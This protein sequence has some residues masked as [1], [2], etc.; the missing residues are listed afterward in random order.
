M[1]DLESL[2]AQHAY[3]KL[4]KVRFASQQTYD[5]RITLFATGTWDEKENN[6][7]TLWKSEETPIGL[8]N[9]V[10]SYEN[11]I[12]AKTAHKGDVRDMQFIGD[13]L[14]LTSSSK[15]CIHVFNCIKSERD[16]AERETDFDIEM[17][18]EDAYKIEDPIITHNLHSF[19]ENK[20]AAATGMAIKP[21]ST[22]DLEIASVGEDGKLVLFK[23]TD[24]NHRQIIDDA[25]ASGLRAV[26]W[27]LSDQIITAGSSGQL[28]LFDCRNS[29]KPCAKFYDPAHPRDSL[30]CLKVNSSQAHQIVSGSS[31]GFVT[32]WDTRNLSK[33]EKQ[34]HPHKNNV[35]EL[36]FHPYRAGILLSCSEDGTIGI[37]DFNP[38]AENLRHHGTLR[39]SI[40]IRKLGSGFNNLAINSIDYNPVARLLIGGNDNQNLLSKELE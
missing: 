12:I 10:P 40:L 17:H 28:R 21:F 18:V 31:Q 14:L 35:Y 19:S 30:N 39:D 9:L 27:P 22:Q 16:E 6:D 15:G 20:S 11:K 24:Q 36:I 1:P 25:D 29:N 2:Y 4:S 37:M 7:L 23:V 26:S 13:S 34:T 5:S 38:H 32:I 3:G 8:R 33:P